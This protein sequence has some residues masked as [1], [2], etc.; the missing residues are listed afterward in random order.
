MAVF[1]KFQDFSEQLVSGTHNFKV[2]TFK[3]A[4]VNTQPSPSNVSLNELT[5]ISA[6]NGYVAGGATSTI[7][8][9]EVSGVASVRG[10]SV[11]FTANGGPIGPFRYAV[12]YNATVANKNL[13][14][15]FDYGTNITLQDTES[16]SVKFNNSEPGQIFQLS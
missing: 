9:V 10:S 4:L 7:T 12:L 3:L 14:G 15:Y 11:V 8:V 6:V 5:E 2:H 13:I 1:N 16:V